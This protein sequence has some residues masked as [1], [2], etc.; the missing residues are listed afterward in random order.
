V[1]TSSLPTMIACCAFEFSNITRF[2]SS[3]SGNEDVIISYTA[4]F[5]TVHFQ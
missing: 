4:R 5:A 3:V 2:A 1:L